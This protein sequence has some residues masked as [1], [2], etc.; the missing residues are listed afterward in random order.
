MA[1]AEVLNKYWLLVCNHNDYMSKA[2]E[3]P[4]WYWVLF[5]VRN[6][7]KEKVIS[8]I[9]FVITGT[10]HLSGGDW[11]KALYMNLHSFMS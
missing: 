9:D 10:A 3:K 7:L 11:I 6:F 2:G 8:L 1:R 5:I 4:P